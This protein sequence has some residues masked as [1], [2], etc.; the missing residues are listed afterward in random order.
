MVTS[1][2]IFWYT[3]SSFIISIFSRVAQCKIAH[4]ILGEVPI[5]ISSPPTEC[6]LP[7]Q[8]LFHLCWQNADCH[9]VI[10][11]QMQQRVAMA[12]KLCH[13]YMRSL[14]QVEKCVRIPLLRFS[15]L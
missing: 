15:C 2:A 7:R 5:A 6:Y 4:E 12:S 3:T 9:N 1:K 14:R 8:F 10:R 11:A 13:K